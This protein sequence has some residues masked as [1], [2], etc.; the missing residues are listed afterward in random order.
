MTDIEHLAQ[1][2]SEQINDELLVYEKVKIPENKYFFIPA[3]EGTNVVRAL[4]HLNF[5]KIDLAKQDFYHAARIA[6]FMSNVYDRRIMDNGTYQITYALLSDNEPLIHRYAFLKNLVNNETSM[7]YQFGNSI[8]NL[9]LNDLEKLDW[10]IRCLE[11]FVNIK[12][13]LGFK[14]VIPLLKAFKNDDEASVKECL[15]VMLVQHKKRN[16]HP[17]FSK[18]ISIDTS[19]FT[20]LAWR[21]G[22][23]INLDSP[24]VPMGLMPIRPL[25]R[26]LDYDFLN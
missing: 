9:L 23:E 26:Y 10:N 14:S 8:Q 3:L 12:Q 18:Y 1:I 22:F 2:Y 21:K 5:G 17:F 24:L 4:Y 7:P 20:K 6:E 16:Q 25:S 19:C 11:R 13:F 15:K